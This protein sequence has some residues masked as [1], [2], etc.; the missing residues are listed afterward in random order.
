MRLVTLCL[1]S[2]CAASASAS[3]SSNDGFVALAGGLQFPNGEVRDIVDTAYGMHLNL[4]LGTYGKAMIGFP[5]FEFDWGHIA[6]KGSRLDTVNVTYCERLVL[7]DGVY[8]GGGVGTAWNRFIRGTEAHGDGEKKN[9]L[10]PCLRGIVG[11]TLSQQFFV[12]GLAFYNG[13]VDGVDANALAVQV[14]VRF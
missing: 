14:G 7:Q 3:V 11:M 9:K 6:G 5:T 13:K 4:G 12:E 10:G 2:A 8:V 1:L